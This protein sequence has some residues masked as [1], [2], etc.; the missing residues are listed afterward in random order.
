MQ[1]ARDRLMSSHVAFKDD[2][3]LDLRD[4]G[5]ARL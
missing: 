5:A 4:C 1:K 2:D 3:L